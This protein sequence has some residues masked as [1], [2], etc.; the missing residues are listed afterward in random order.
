[1]AGKLRPGKLRRVPTVLQMEASE[2]GAASLAMVMASF[3][4]YMPLEQLRVEMG[5]SRDGAS[6]G[7]LRRCAGR[8]G[9]ECRAMKR[10]AAQLRLLPMP[11]ILHWDGSHFLVL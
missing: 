7:S 3:G 9:L 6:A 1:M 4:R 5:V 2:C 10:E 8:Y 11:C